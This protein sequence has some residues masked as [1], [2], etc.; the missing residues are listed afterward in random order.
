MC[1]NILTVSIVHD[2]VLILYTVET[3]KIESYTLY[4]CSIYLHFVNFDVLL[5]LYVGNMIYTIIYKSIYNIVFQLIFSSFKTHFFYPVYYQL[6]TYFFLFKRLFIYLF[7]VLVILV[8]AFFFIAI[9]CFF[10]FGFLVL[11]YS[12]ESLRPIKPK[13]IFQTIT[14]PVF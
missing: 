2:K 3:N 4:L 14:I 10:L 1:S 13:S 5:F 12:F 6:L 8:S 11:G 9:C 7:F